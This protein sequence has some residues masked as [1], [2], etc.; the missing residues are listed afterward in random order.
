MKFS[1]LYIPQRRDIHRHDPRPSPRLACKLVDPTS[2]FAPTPQED[3][4][5]GGDGDADDDDDDAAFNAKS[6]GRPNRAFRPS[7]LV[8]PLLSPRTDSWGPL[9]ITQYHFKDVTTVRIFDKDHK[10]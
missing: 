3:E 7:R 9:L 10:I 1:T 6:D 8:I 2:K 4:E 5:D